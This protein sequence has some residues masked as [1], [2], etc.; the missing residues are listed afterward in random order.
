MNNNMKGIYLGCGKA[1]HNGYDIVYQD[2]DG[3]RDIGGDM[4]DI[5]LSP[6]DFIIA[7]PPCNYWSRCNYRRD[8]SSYALQ[9]KHLLI[10][11]L[12]KLIN[13][14]K[15]FLVENVRNDNLFGQY[16]LLEKNCL[17]VVI[18]RH[19]YWTNVLFYN[20]D[21]EQRQDFK[22]GG[23]VI[24]YDDMDNKYHQGG[25]NVHNVVAAF[26]ECLCNESYLILEKRFNKGVYVS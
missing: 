14:G 23:Y 21:I 18:G 4:L 6:Y 7:T 12:E 8:K 5:D 3:K 15:P 24:R 10:D 1:A 26:L 9:T 19:R 20:R 16:G 11:L 22:Y 17:T 25:Y 13:C 2:I